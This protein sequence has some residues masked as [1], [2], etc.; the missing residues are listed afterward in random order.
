MM[1]YRTVRSALEMCTVLIWRISAEVT[2]K[3]GIV[4]ISS[5]V[6]A[7]APSTNASERVLAVL[8]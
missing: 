1:M 6:Q 2:T 7:R 8:A 4:K 3:S 5:G